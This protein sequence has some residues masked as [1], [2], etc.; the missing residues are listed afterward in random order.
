MPS[1]NLGI[2]NQNGETVENSVSAFNDPENLKKFNPLINNAEITRENLK[3]Q[4]S[5]T[6][7]TVDPTKQKEV[8]T[9][10][11]SIILISIV[12]LIFGYLIFQL[13]KNSQ[14]KNNTAIK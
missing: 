1:G 13:G 3:K 10:N 2:K 5:Q 7:V 11:N 6:I 12:L 8:Q 14:N 4:K 9:S